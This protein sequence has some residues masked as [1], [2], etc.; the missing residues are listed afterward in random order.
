MEEAVPERP[1]QEA[2]PDRPERPAK[3]SARVDLEEASNVCTEAKKIAP[4]G[5]EK[6]VYIMLL[7]R[8][9]VWFS[10]L[11]YGFLILPFT[12]HR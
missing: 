5:S 1:V 2:A 10:F 3:E 9:H 11:L 6:V 8:Y 4:S 12:F 7:Y